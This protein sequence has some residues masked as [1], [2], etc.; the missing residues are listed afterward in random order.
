[1]KGLKKEDPDIA[2]DPITWESVVSI[3][4]WLAPSGESDGIL[5]ACAVLL[6]FDLYA[7]PGALLKLTSRC[8]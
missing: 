2:R 8:P 5:A 1:M 4:E 7:R 6:D 3:D